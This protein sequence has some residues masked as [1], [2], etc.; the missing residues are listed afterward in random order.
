M[1]DNFEMSSNNTKLWCPQFKRQILRRVK[2]DIGRISVLLVIVSA[3]N[4]EK[5]IALRCI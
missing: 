1:Y 4:R 2:T 5:D 3:I